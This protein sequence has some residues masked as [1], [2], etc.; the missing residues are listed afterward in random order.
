MNA[1][2]NTTH[3]AHSD[4]KMNCNNAMWCVDV[5]DLYV[6]K[7]FSFFFFVVVWL[8]L[9]VDGVALRCV[10]FSSLLRV[11]FFSIVILF[12]RQLIAI[13]FDQLNISHIYL[14]HTHNLNY[15]TKN[16]IEKYS[17]IFR[18]SIIT[19][20]LNRTNKNEIL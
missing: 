14:M 11:V 19:L 18:D 16:L 9:W 15:N 10:F 6:E 1:Q 4:R 7:L 12:H 8:L 3:H 2:T 20:K 13:A 17:F 5:M